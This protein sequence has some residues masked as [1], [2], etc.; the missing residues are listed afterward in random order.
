MRNQIV[1]DGNSLLIDD[2]IVVSRGHMKVSLSDDEQFLN[3]ISEGRKFYLES[4]VY[5]Y[6]DKMGVGA[7][8]GKIIPEEKRVAFQ[9]R[10]IDSLSCG[11]GDRLPD[12]VVRAAMLLRANSLVKEGCSAIGLDKI[13]RIIYFLNNGI[14]PVMRKNGSVGASGDLVPLSSIAAAIE[15][16]G[17]VMYQGKI[18]DTNKLYKKLGLDELWLREKEGLSL[19]NG[20]SAMTGMAALALYDAFNILALA[21][22]A[23]AMVTEALG[24][25]TDPFDK[26]VHEMKNH[27]GQKEAASSL[28][29]LLSKSAL[30]KN[31]EELRSE[32]KTQA[33]GASSVV[34]STIELQDPYCIR[35]S[36]QLFGPVLETLDMVEDWITNEANSANDNPIVNLKERKVHHTGNFSGFYI[37][38]AMDF[39]RLAMFDVADELNSLKERILNE[40]YNRGLGASLAGEEPGF[41][42][43]FKGVGICLADIF[44]RIC[45]LANPYSIHRRTTESFNQDIVSFGF[46]SAELSLEQND[47]LRELLAGVLIIAA[48]GV[49]I[50]SGK[51][52][53]KMSP[54]TRIIYQKIR[55]AVAFLDKDRPMGGDIS[56][57][58]ALIK[59][60]IF[61]E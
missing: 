55:G 33:E 27:E 53:S 5:A 31:I 26:F 25:M 23:T 24:G 51:D 49:D 45:Y 29:L 19:V 30:T 10:L 4:G 48:Q 56:K 14:T 36:P 18:Y 21:L 12:D 9:E 35:C 17:K 37:A 34:E 22:A 50:R 38:R 20:T 1:L 43:G 46:G 54:N 59:R 16:N 3:K 44:G 11:V 42:S 7:N 61:F 52:P 6:G 47:R 13:E 57:I 28:R 60:E 58:A 41:N 39:L 2:I 32:V 40:K 15:G 8:V